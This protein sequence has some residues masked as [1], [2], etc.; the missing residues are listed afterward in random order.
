MR[1]EPETCDDV[2]EADEAEVE[3]GG[4]K[5]RVGMEARLENEG[6]YVM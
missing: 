4:V 6:V 1:F 3:A 5:T 2:G